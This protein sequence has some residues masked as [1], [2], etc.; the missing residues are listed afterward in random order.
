[1]RIAYT[2][3]RAFTLETDCLP[4]RRGRV[5]RRMRRQEH[6]RAVGTHYEPT[7]TIGPTSHVVGGTAQPVATSVRVGTDTG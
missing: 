4:A 7:R 1:M 6:M 5:F 2:I 3:D